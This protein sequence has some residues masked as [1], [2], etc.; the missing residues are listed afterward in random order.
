M[1]TRM[2][3]PKISGWAANVFRPIAST[4]IIQGEGAIG[5]GA[6]EDG[7]IILSIHHSDGASLAVAFE[8]KDAMRLA[9]A[10]LERA[11]ALSEG[12]NPNAG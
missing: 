5:T 6:L 3:Q 2:H 1:T 8:R 4:G 12:D 9:D 10:L 11:I 7:R